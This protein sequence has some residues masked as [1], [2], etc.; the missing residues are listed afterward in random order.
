MVTK[1]YCL[2]DRL[3]PDIAQLKHSVFRSL[4]DKFSRPYF[5]E[6]FGLTAWKLYLEK[7]YIIEAYDPRT[8]DPFEAIRG[9][10]YN[11]DHGLNLI[12]GF[13]KE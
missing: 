10:F 12:T 4:P 8:N 9:E 1:S 2:T 13:P 11:P 3:P 7:N 6:H 5:V